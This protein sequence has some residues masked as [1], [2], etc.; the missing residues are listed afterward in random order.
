MVYDDFTNDE[1]LAK[2]IAA[3]WRWMRASGEGD[4]DAIRRVK[5]DTECLSAAPHIAHV[6]R[7]GNPGWV[8]RAWA[9]SVVEP[10][11]T[12]EGEMLVA[13]DDFAGLLLP[14]GVVVE[15][16]NDFTLS[17]IHWPRQQVA[18]LR[19]EQRDQIAS[20]RGALREPSPWQSFGYHQGSHD[21]DGELSVSNAPT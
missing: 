21:T 4:P 9:A 5:R 14:E 3:V 16:Y 2:G 1:Q 7:E 11:Y 13:G 19:A 17:V 8:D 20:G 6:I 10:T 18:A 15:P 12:H